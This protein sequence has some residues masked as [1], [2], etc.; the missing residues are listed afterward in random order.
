MI[1]RGLVGWL[2]GGGVGYW[3]WM[4]WDWITFFFFTATTCILVCYDCDDI[5]KLAYYELLTVA[6]RCPGPRSPG[7]FA[8]PDRFWRFIQTT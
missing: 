7:I 2:V 3:Y 6:P 1:S 8:V 4:V 5:L